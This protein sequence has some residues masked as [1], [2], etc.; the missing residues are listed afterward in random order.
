M[1]S[2]RHCLPPF[3]SLPLGRMTRSRQRLGFVPLPFL[4]PTRTAL[5]DADFTGNRVWQRIKGGVCVAK[6]VMTCWISRRWQEFVTARIASGSG[7]SVFN[8]MGRRSSRF[9]INGCNPKC[10]VDADTS[11]G[12]AV[13]RHFCGD[14]GSP[15]YSIVP[16]SPDS[17][18]LKTGT[19]DDTGD[20]E[21]QF[22]VWCDSK[23][24]WVD[25]PDGQ[26]KW[27]HSRSVNG[28]QL[29]SRPFRLG[30][31][32]GIEDSTNDQT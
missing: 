8:V 11:S 23:Q 21:P 1:E 10:Y 16:G 20:F 22:H 24:R 18:F 14:C 27:Q 31:I 5:D 17:L 3:D 9:S 7:V 25:I 19:L 12:S 6:S 4:D 29:D 13:E 2:N 28:L 30:S 15:I 26:P 32:R